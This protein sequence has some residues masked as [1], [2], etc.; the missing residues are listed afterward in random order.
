MANVDHRYETTRTDRYE[1]ENRGSFWRWLLPLI[2]LG[3]LALLA[4]SFMNHPRQVNV[5]VPNPTTT[6]PVN[7][8][9]TTPGAMTPGAA[10]GAPRT[11]P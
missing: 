11:T 8:G 2:A 6:A 7:P 1:G 10:P 5:N 4:F 3:I 9:A